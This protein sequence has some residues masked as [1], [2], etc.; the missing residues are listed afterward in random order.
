MHREWREWGRGGGG[1]MGGGKGRAIDF[2]WAA[3]SPR[4]EKGVP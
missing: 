3:S 2:P 4:G 1:E